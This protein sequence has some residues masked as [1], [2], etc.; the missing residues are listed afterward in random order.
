MGTTA[1]TLNEIDCGGTSE[2]GHDE[3]MI[4]YQSDA[5]MAH[6]FPAGR[7]AHSMAKGD[8]W[9]NINLRMEFGND[10]LVTLYDQDSSLDPKLADYLVSND[11]TPDSMPSTITLSNPNGAKYT[12]KIGS[13]S[14][15]K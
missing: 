7:D 8:T 5:G 3:I 6:L 13:V 10:C 1:F 15:T 9:T 11:Y 4:L 14:V 2:S 12:L